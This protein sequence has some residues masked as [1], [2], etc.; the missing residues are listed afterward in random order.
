M[1][2]NI[3]KAANLGF[4]TGVRHAMDIIT[5][6]AMERGGIETLG[7]L[8]HNRQVMQKLGTL[9]VTIVDNL[10]LVQGDVVV[11]S[12]HGASPDTGEAI[13]QRGLKAI[14]TTCAFVKRA[15][16][17][18]KKLAADG[19]CVVVFGDVNHPEVRGILGWADGQGLATLNACDIGRLPEMPR[20]LGLLSQTTQIPSD[21]NSFI[22]D[23]L[24]LAFTKDAEIRIIDT[25][26]HE[27]RARQAETLSLARSSDLVLVIGGR[28]SA[29]T[30]RLYELCAT[31]A[32]TRLIE[33]AADIDPAWLD[34]KSD[35][36]ITAGTSTDNE[37][38]EEVAVRLAELSRLASS[39]GLESR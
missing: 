24:D 33:T 17:A 31:V 30:K 37:T 3:N 15:Q 38:I 10:V 25:I 28:S 22:K 7:A 32:D 20:R 16:S 39:A 36:G 8:V 13:K 18:A 14:D 27:T 19:F 12:A 1:S 11:I 5:K 23:V 35:I 2:I 6:A 21:F 26:C 29:N 34:G 4:C 9:G